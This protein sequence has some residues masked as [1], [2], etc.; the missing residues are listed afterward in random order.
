MPWLTNASVCKELSS[1]IE[2]LGE[3]LLLFEDSA[4]VDKQGTDILVKIVEQIKFV[5][6]NTN[7][8]KYGTNQKAASCQD[9]Q[10]TF[11]CLP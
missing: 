8:I 9:P 2:V 7:Q 11:S 1:Q 4:P 6:Q 5:N 3:I 10:A